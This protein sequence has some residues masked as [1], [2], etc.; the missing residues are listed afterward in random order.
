MELLSFYQMDEDE[1]RRLTAGADRN[2][3]DRPR[4]EFRAPRGV[5]S[6]TVGP[7]LEAI[8]RLRPDP[9][10][11]AD[12]LGLQAEW[13]A[14]FLALTAAYQA[15]TDAE[16]LLT[17]K[18]APEAMQLLVPAA[19]SGHRY[20]RYLVADHALRTALTLQRENRL[21]DA[22]VFFSM[23][24]R[25]EPDNHDAL[26]GLGYVDL[27]LGEREEATRVLQ[28]AYTRYPESGG[29]AYRLG[30]V[31]Q[32][33]GRV[34]EAETLY[35]RAIDL[36]PTLSA[37]HGLLGQILL[38]SGRTGEALM[39][40]EEAIDRGDPTEGPWVGRVVAQTALGRRDDAIESAREAVQ[41]FPTSPTALEALAGAAT[42]A[43]RA[44]EAREARRRKDAL[45]P[46]SGTR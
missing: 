13:R 33:E 26:V 6:D 8:G 42:A 37:P 25:Y 20:A 1:V 15:V 39:R 3:D 19:E 35:R 22:R 41:R 2:T 17:H 10:A 46:A 31:R 38:Q 16:I 23:A 12:R 21:A 28:D 43:G 29:A 45:A 44:D 40:F 9:E 5:F 11:R 27:F 4:T 36:Q 14:S 18:R 32:M 30:L 24:V 34:G 7:N